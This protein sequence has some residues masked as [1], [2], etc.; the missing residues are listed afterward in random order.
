VGDENLFR[1]IRLSADLEL[2][3][4]ERRQAGEVPEGA[5]P[6]ATVSVVHAFGG[7]VT[8][9]WLVERMREWDEVLAAH[10]RELRQ[11]RTAKTITAPEATIH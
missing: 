3:E 6:V 5:E 1:R 10:R 9:E 8:V 2:P 4:A 11:R 7:G